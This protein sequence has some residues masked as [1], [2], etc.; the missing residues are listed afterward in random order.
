MRAHYYF[1]DT[2]VAG[3]STQVVSQINLLP[4]LGDFNQLINQAQFYQQYKFKRISYS[5]KVV[6]LLGGA[7]GTKLPTGNL[8]PLCGLMDVFKVRLQSDQIPDANIANYTSYHKLTHHWSDKV[9]SGSFVPFVSVSQG[10]SRT[11]KQNQ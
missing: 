3:G 8:Q 10:D 7:T 11:F 4:T 6:N 1:N 5:L 2:I 9:I